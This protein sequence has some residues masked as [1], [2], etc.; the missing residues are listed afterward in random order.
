MNRIFIECKNDNINYIKKILLKIPN[1]NY[2][3]IVYN[4]LYTSCVYGCIKILKHLIEETKIDIN[5]VNKNNDSGLML[6]C[7]NNKEEVVDY[8]L[9]NP[10]IDINYMNKNNKTNALIV[11]CI[12]GDYNI[13]KKIYEH[14]N[15]DRYCKSEYNLSIFLLS[16][17]YNNLDIII[18]LLENNVNIY[19]TDYLGNNG[20]II[21]CYE[22]N[23][24]ILKYLIENTN[25][26]VKKVNEYKNNILSV[27]CY[28]NYVDIVKYLVEYI[29]IDINIKDLNGNNILML[30]SVNNNLEIL[31]YLIKNTSIDINEYNNYGETIL[32][33]AIH[34]INIDMIKMLVKNKK[35]ELNKIRYINKYYSVLDI[36][37]NTK[38]DDVRIY[39]IIEYI[40]MN[41]KVYIQKNA[42]LDSNVKN[43][44]I[45]L[46]NKKIK[47][48]ILSINI[49]PYDLMNI[50][51]EYC[52]N[53]KWD[54]IDLLN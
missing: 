13:F 37:L 5:N 34:I 46:V 29:D 6:A 9:Q 48:K 52:M 10:E 21:A 33:L 53:I 44:I 49:L 24:E 11:C 26:D 25:I 23:I 41:K 8:L 12:E 47:K 22:N 54:E 32:S 39:E 14:D 17:Q 1:E 16:C 51:S 2:E 15:I 31:L 45:N 43:M 4:L 36:L 35:I 20:L 40:I 27:A 50:V 3:Y 7:Y 19:E 38:I 28:E 18:Y 42:V 30:A